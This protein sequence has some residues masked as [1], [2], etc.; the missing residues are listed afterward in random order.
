[1]TNKDWK[2]SLRQG[3][4]EYSQTPPEGLWEAL[5]AAGAVGK[6]KAGSRAAKAG[7]GLLAWLTGV[8]APVWW[9]LA[10]VAA[11]VAAVLL[12]V[13]PGG[14]QNDPVLS[15]EEPLVAQVQE[16]SEPEPEVVGPVSTSEMKAPAAKKPAPAVEGQAPAEDAP[17]AAVESPAESN[18]VKAASGESPAVTN[19]VKAASVESPA[20]SEEG[21]AASGEP[22]SGMDFPSQPSGVTSVPLSRQ[23]SRRHSLIAANLYGGGM[24]GSATFTNT[25][26]YGIKTK[27]GPNMASRQVSVLGRNRVT[28]TTVTRKMDFQAGLMLSFDFSRHWGLETGLQYTRLASSSQST[29]GSLASTTEEKI[30]YLGVPLH[31]VFT[32]LRLPLLSLYVSAGPELEYG[33]SRTWDVY[34]IINSVPTAIDHGGE[35]P[36]DWVFSGSLNAG[37]QLKPFRHGAFFVQPGVVVRNILETS[38]E[39]YYTD[40]PVSFRLAAG[41]RITF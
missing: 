14:R 41:Y 33:V 19:D 9:S 12:V 39:S 20:V 1:M 26:S 38:P 30:G 23:A 15:M 31:V 4:S 3:L 34:D 8:R 22:E 36:G 28:E 25:V 21:N 32:P 6:E 18:D 2:D 13:N 16:V 37:V 11:A 24:P 10:G 35:T 5:E 27:D 29:T 7:A 17:A 40:H